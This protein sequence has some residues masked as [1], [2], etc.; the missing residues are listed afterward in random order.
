MVPTD[1]LV[2]KLPA[3]FVSTKVGALVSS[4]RR[5]VFYTAEM[6]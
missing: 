6:R 2:E 4:L 1:G 5:S 3:F